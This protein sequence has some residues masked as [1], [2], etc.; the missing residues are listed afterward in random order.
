M[1]IAYGTPMHL[2]L[3][4]LMYPAALLTCSWNRHQTS[5]V[6]GKPGLMSTFSG[7]PG[8]CAY[9]SHKPPSRSVVKIWPAGIKAESMLAASSLPSAK[10]SQPP[11]HRWWKRQ[12]CSILGWHPFC[13][14]PSVEVIWCNFEQFCI[15]S[16]VEFPCKRNLFDVRFCSCSVPRENL[17]PQVWLTMYTSNHITNFEDENIIFKVHEV[18]I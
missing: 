11:S 14:L 12:I 13:F 2:W 16:S 17:E 3:K 5:T 8:W 9:G 10:S 15:Q 18:T 6:L 4:C 1:P 7:S